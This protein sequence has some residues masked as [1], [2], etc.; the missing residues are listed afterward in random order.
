M[1]PKPRHFPFLVTSSTERA[2]HLLGVTLLCIAVT[3]D[4]RQTSIT[5]KLPGTL[6]GDGEPSTQSLIWGK[7]FIDQ[8]SWVSS[9]AIL[10]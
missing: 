7:A 9:V 1:H 2:I 8:T 5:F 4:R 3:T 10:G 6:A